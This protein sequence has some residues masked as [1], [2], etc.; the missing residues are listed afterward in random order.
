MRAWLIEHGYIRT[1]AQIK[2]DEIVSMFK[3]KYN[4]ASAKTQ[5]WTTWKDA[6][7]RAYLRMHGVSESA[8]PGDR[9]TLLRT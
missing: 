5:A 6:R 1:D 2:K 9:P 3:S 7:L 4:N 8:I